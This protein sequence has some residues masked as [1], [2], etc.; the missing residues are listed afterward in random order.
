LGARKVG[1]IL[2]EAR[3]HGNALAWVVVGLGLN[4]TNEVP[5]ELRDVADTLAAA[6]PGRSAADLAEP[7]ADVIRKIDA[8]SP[9]LG[10]EE[11]ERLTEPDWSSGRVV[12]HPTEGVADGIDSAGALLVR[13]ADGPR[14]A[15]RVGPLELA[16]Y[17]WRG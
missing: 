2:C 16:D 14:V 17:P 6:L 13:L 9:A 12:Q 11:I 1:G 10:T 7:L 8:T 3:W 5:E 15:V 4:I